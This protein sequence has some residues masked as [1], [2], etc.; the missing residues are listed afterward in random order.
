MIGGS[1]SISLTNRSGSGSRRAKNIRTRH[2]GLI[3]LI[4]VSW[5]ELTFTGRFAGKPGGSSLLFVFKTKVERRPWRFAS[6][7]FNSIFFGLNHRVHRV[8]GFF[9]SRL[10]WDSPTRSLAGECVPPSFG[11]WEGGGYTLACGTE[12]PNFRRGDRH[13]G[14][15]GIYV[16]CSAR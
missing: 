2:F 15:L 10:N 11:S 14:I 4:A 9:S 16:L 1:G 3:D 6:S 12:G 8:Q 5:Y 13:F 7:Y